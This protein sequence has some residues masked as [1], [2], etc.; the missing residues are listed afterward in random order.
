MKSYLDIAQCEWGCVRRAGS[1]FARLHEEDECDTDHVGDG[2]IVGRLSE[3]SGF[4]N[5]M[6]DE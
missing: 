1:V 2:G 4:E 6:N 3:G 5:M